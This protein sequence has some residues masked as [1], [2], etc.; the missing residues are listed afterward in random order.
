MTNQERLKTSGLSVKRVLFLSLGLVLELFTVFIIFLNT[1]ILLDEKIVFYIFGLAIYVL[2]IYIMLCERK[3]GKEIYSNTSY[4]RWLFIFSLKCLIVILISIIYTTL[5]ILLVA[6]FI[7]T[8]VSGPMASIINILFDIT[9]IFYIGKFTSFD[10]IYFIFQVIFGVFFSYLYKLKI[11]ERES[12]DA[13]SFLMAAFLSLFVTV[14]F[15]LKYNY[16][17]FN[18]IGLGII[19]SMIFS[20]LTYILSNKM[21][22]WIY[23]ER[24]NIYKMILDPN[25]SIRSEIKSFSKKDYE[26]AKRV[27]YFSGMA[28]KMIGADIYV[29]VAGGLYYRYP[30]IYNKRVTKKSIKIL[31]NKCVPDEVIQIIKEYDTSNFPPSSKES[32][33]VNIVDNVITRNELAEEKGI[34]SG[35]NNDMIIYQA[36][37][38][39]SQDGTYDNSGLSMNEYLRIRDYLIK[40]NLLIDIEEEII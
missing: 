27:S 5:P 13:L 17:E 15:Y 19:F 7:L 35:W 10:I 28:A 18:T 21:M 4:R 16:F 2:G 31:E 8:M 24:E 3:I 38:Q 20:L 11:R 29:A 25:F 36:L 30:K 32:A 40:E 33:I 14:Y 34:E 6:G 1:D 26:H 39:L 37:N 12:C 22:T 9:L 23:K